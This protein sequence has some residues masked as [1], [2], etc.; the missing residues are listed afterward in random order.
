[1]V[2]HNPWFVAADGLIDKEEWLFGAVFLRQKRVDF[3][4]G[5]L[6]IGSPCGGQFFGGERRVVQQVLEFAVFQIGAFAHVCH[7]AG[8]EVG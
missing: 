2:R 5:N 8:I 1:M 7:G 3:H 4:G 6:V